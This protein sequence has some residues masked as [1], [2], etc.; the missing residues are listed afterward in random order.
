MSDTLVPG[1][2]VSSGMSDGHVR[3]IGLVQRSS[4]MSDDIQFLGKNLFSRIDPPIK[5]V[6]IAAR[7]S[8]SRQEHSPSIKYRREKI[9]RGALERNPNPRGEIRENGE[10]IDKRSWDRTSTME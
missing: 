7:G 2:C 3:R 9:L 1:N 6:Q 8:I 10:N 4:G 5:L